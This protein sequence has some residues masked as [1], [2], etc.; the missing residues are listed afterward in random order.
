M[1]RAAVTVQFSQRMALSIPVV[2]SLPDALVSGQISSRERHVSSRAKSSGSARGKFT[3]HA[4]VDRARSIKDLPEMIRKCLKPFPSSPRE[5]AVRH[6]HWRLIHS[7]RFSEPSLSL[8]HSIVAVLGPRRLHGLVRLPKL[9]LDPPTTRKRFAPVA[10]SHSTTLSS[11]N[12]VLQFSPLPLSH[13]R[14]HCRVHAVA[15]RVELRTVC[16]MSRPSAEL[17]PRL[18]EV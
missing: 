18:W 8:P 9:A 10:L 13:V 2:I 6:T 5:F 1:T 16:L 17:A 7:F 11:N 4:P 3:K 12:L 15:E 14:F